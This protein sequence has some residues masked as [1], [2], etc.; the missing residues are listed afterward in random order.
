MKK[1]VGKPLWQYFFVSRERKRKTQHLP[2]LFKVSP[3]LNPLSL[4]CTLAL[5]LTVGGTG[6]MLS[7]SAGLSLYLLLFILYFHTRANA[8][9]LHAQRVLKLDQFIEYDEVEVDIKIINTALT[10]SPSFQLTDRFTASQKDLV[11]FS[12]PTGISAQTKIVK[13]YKRVCDAGSGKMELGP[14]S[15]RVSDFFGIFYFDVIEE[16]PQSIHILPKVENLPEIPIQGH[17]NS[18]RYGNYDLGTRGQSVKFRGVREYSRGDSLRHVAWKITAKSGK[19]MV[20]EFDNMV[21][22]QVSVALNLNP[23]E[24]IGSKK[25]STLEVSKDV[26]L[27]IISQQKE[28]GN[29]VNFLTNDWTFEL[30]A[31]SGFES[32]ATKLSE[33]TFTNETF[34][35]A[36]IADEP[37]LFCNRL[38]RFVSPGSVLFYVTP[39]TDA[40]AQ[41]TIKNLKYLKMEGVQVFVIFLDTSSFIGQ[42]S[43]IIDFKKRIFFPPTKDLFK[44]TMEL[45]KNGIEVILLQAGVP[46]EECFLHITG[47]VA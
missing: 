45:Q 42:L 36:T 5:L 20:K 23:Q 26:C 27:S 18:N 17:A 12:F 8:Y 40:S 22:S 44:T 13:R 46:Y 21:N 1:V 25:I 37:Q 33:I 11:E 31:S 4:I 14:I 15:M 28:F 3:R 9:N 10:R 24:H 43:P 16:A 38:S 41:D 6:S 32:L 30:S 29:T 7:L 35:G 34:D 2:F 19:L 39:Y 47:K